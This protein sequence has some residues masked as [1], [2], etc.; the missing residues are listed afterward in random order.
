MPVLDVREQAEW[1]EGLIRGAIHVPCHDT[2]AYRAAWLGTSRWPR[3]SCAALVSGCYQGAKL[4]SCT[5]VG[6]AGR[7]L[8]LMVTSV[9]HWKSGR[10][11]FPHTGYPARSQTMST[12]SQ[13]MSTTR[14]SRGRRAIRWITE[15]FA[16]YD[17]ARRRQLEI[18][19]GR[20]LTRQERPPH[21]SGIQTAKRPRMVRR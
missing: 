9:P 6:A 7:D 21:P 18:M 13:T 10:G 15:T 5:H 3:A 17:Y 20:D 11:G 16:E 1:N 4:S 14:E 2:R 8:A 19:L 12:T